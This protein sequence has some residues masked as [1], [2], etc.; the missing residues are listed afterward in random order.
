MKAAADINNTIFHAG[1]GARGIIAVDGPG[2][3][4]YFN[5]VNFA[6]E[7]L[8]LDGQL[9][10]QVSWAEYRRMGLHSFQLMQTN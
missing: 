8:L 6:G 10:R 2:G 5:I 4:H 9:G 7:V 3:G 1:E